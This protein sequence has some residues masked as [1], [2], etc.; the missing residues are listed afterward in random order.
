[1]V[2]SFPIVPASSKGLWL[3]FGVISL[4]LLGILSLLFVSARGATRSHFEVSAEGLR[5]SGDLYG[6]FIP[7]SA[8]QVAEAR[9][10][11]LRS[12]RELAP[13]LRTMGTSVP[14]YS[15]GWFRLRNGRKALLYLTDRGRAVYVPTTQGYDLLLSPQDGGRFVERLRALGAA[16]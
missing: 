11:D 5:L 2:E 1:M 8:L 16:R 10:V 4:L 3:I 15:S 12:E 14:G 7:R 9:L 13:R 6:R